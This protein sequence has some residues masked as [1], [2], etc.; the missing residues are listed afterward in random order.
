M[1]NISPQ[2][3]QRPELRQTLAPQ[4][5]QSLAILQMSSLE[6]DQYIDQQ[7]ETNPFLD[8]T[9]PR[10]IILSEAVDTLASVDT[11]DYDEPAEGAYEVAVQKKAEESRSADASLRDDYPPDEGYGTHNPDLEARY[12]YYQDSITRSESL[13]AHLLNQLHLACSDP[14]QIAIGERI[15]IGDINKDGLFTGSLKEIAEE[16]NTSVEK[17]TEVL[18]II[19][20]FEPVGVGAASLIDC[21]AM[22]ID[23]E[24]PDEPLLKQMLLE[25][26]DKLLNR[27]FALIADALGIS[28]ERVQEL[29]RML[30]RLNPFPGR[31][32][33][34]EEP[35]YIYPEITVEEYNG[36]YI[37]TLT[38]DNLSGLTINEEYIRNIRSQKKSADDEKYVAAYADSARLLLRNIERRE[39]T[40]KKVAQ[41]IVDLQRSFMEN[42]PGSMVPLTLEEIAVKVKVHEST[43]S[44]AISGKYME[45]PQGIFEMKYFFSSGL[46]A[47]GGEELSSTAVCEQIK[48]IIEGENKKSPLSD[49]KITDM[50]NAQGIS[51][52]RRTVSKYRELLNILPARFRKVF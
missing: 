28:E 31:E 13:S 36:D 51:V 23:V 41:A 14:D 24:F 32:Y 21:L 29:N 20:K 52:A 39:D 27:R 22:Q 48:A 3:Q 8:R 43:V 37:A 15:I 6:L 9:S 47:A 35:V 50:L 4:M 19:R 30:A 7:V 1:L 42:G 2:I 45:T 18:E 33:S 17:V 5:Q 12:Q 11:A 46:S 10:E 25:H 40:I 44:R 49:Q 16:L 34:Q 26:W 38:A